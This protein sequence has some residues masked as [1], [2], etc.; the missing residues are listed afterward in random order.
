MMLNYGQVTISLPSVE[1]PGHLWEEG[2]LRQGF[3]WSDGL[4]S[5]GVPEHA[6]TCRMDVRL[7]SDHEVDPRCISSVCVPFDA[8]EG[9]A[10]IGS[11]FGAEEV[12]LPP[13]RYQ[14]IFDVMPG[15]GTWSL[16]E[17]GQSISG[18]YSYLITIGFRPS[19]APGFAILKAGG[20]VQSETVLS[21]RADHA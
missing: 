13:G 5:F 11:V 8:R 19:A 20:A 17:D 10:L 2:H 3:A 18:E 7:V 9:R 12:E 4:A 16:E 1:R 15:E 6:E 21:T 14:L